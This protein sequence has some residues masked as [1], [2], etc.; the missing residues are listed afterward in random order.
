MHGRG[1]DGQQ[2]GRAV[3]TESLPAQVHPIVGAQGVDRKGLV[4]GDG[5]RVGE[6][7]RQR[8]ALL[9]VGDQ[10]IGVLDRG[11]AYSRHQFP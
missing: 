7:G 4:V 6:A 8:P 1:G 9:G 2:P 3:A 10:R 11:A 5:P